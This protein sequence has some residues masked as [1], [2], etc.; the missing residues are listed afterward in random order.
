[1]KEK[2]DQYQGEDQV[3]L[4]LG[5]SKKNAVRMPV[6]TSACAELESAVGSIFGADC[7]AIR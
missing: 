2:V 4:V 3:I 7:V 1:M 6:R 5:E